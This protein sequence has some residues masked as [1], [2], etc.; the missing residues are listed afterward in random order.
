ME[1]HFISTN[2]RIDAI[3][4]KNDDK[5]MFIDGGFKYNAKKEIKYLDKIGVTH[6][7]YYVGTH[8]HM[9]HVEAAP[10]IIQKYGIQNVI[11]GRE[12]CNGSGKDYCSWYTIKLFAKEQKIS[13]SNVNA[14]AL[15]PG[16]SFSLGG[17]KITCLGPLSVNNNL[18]RGDGY[19]NYNS[20]IFRL[21][22]GNTSFMFTG[23]NSSTKNI[24]ASYQKYGDLMK[25]D[26]LKNP[27]HSGN[28]GSNAYKIFGAKYVVF[29]TGSSSLPSSSCLNSLKS[30]GAKYYII[31]KGYN[32]N[33][34]FT[35]DGKKINVTSNYT[36]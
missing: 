16:D 12:K 2:S 31:A 34:V 17:A 33:V 11:V 6:I 15:V 5:S 36:P 18:A 30:L 14:R 4:I 22:Y 8:S 27:H 29:P 28:I 13:L 3:Y 35:S 25:V 19:Q 20:I 32:E 1:I 21:E 23:D 26:M 10:S 24:K 7:D 9:N